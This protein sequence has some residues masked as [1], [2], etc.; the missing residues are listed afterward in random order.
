MAAKTFYWK[1]A[2]PTGA[3]LHRSLQD[4]GVAPTAATTTTGWN[5]GT[6]VLG[7]SCI[8]NGGSEVSRTSGSWGATLQPSAA[9][10]QTVGDCWRSEN[11]LTGVFANTNWTFN[12]GIRSVTAAYVGRLKLAVRVWRS[13][14]ANGSGA[15]ELTSGRVAS[16]A[17]SAN[18]STSADTTVSWTWSPGGTMTLNGEYLFVQVGIEITSAGGGTTQDIDFRV[19]STYTLVTPNF[20]PLHTTTGAIAGAG[21]TVSGSAART[22]VHANTGALAGPG[23]TVAGSAARASSAVSHATTGALA[24]P[25]AAVVG[26]ASSKTARPSTG[27]LT[28][29]GAVAAGSAARTRQHASSGAIA[30]A[31]ATVSAAATRTRAHA[32][33]GILAAAGGVVAGTASHSSGPVSHSA[34]GALAG[35]GAGVVGAASSA[36]VRATTGALQGSGSVVAGSSSRT[37][38][39]ASA[40]VIAGPGAAVAGAASRA[41]HGVTVHDTAGV[42]VAAGAAMTAT[43]YVVAPSRLFRIRA[44]NRLYRVRAEDSTRVLAG[45][46]RVYRV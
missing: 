20:S 35:S 12:F 14:N 43:A 3:T 7:Q 32:T 28:G 40:G 16:A 18:L 27:A 9:P 37:H 33:S 10:S 36:T 42:L 2:V 11:T 38:V 19:A 5:A 41:G 31:G 13:S 17:T 23:S 34:S 45:E 6:N 46:N 15:V 1:D 21:T 22:R 26:A 24:G 8:Q 4:G 29:A 44:E 30:G 25:G 39:H